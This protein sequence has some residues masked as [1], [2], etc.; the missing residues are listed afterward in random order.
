MG[1]MEPSF[2]LDDFENVLGVALFAVGRGARSVTID[3]AAIQ[4]LRRRFASRMRAAVNEPD[5]RDNWR[6]E[7]PYLIAQAEALGH[8]AARL[9][10]Q[11]GRRSIAGRDVVI[12]IAKVRGHLPVGGR[13][14]PF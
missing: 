10:K 9:A 5:W 2:L 4:F 1:D 7:A 6:R 14:C 13:W 11:E 12:A 8:H 3:L